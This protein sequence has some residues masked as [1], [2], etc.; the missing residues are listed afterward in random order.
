MSVYPFSF[1]T[2]HDDFFVLELLSDTGSSLP[3][4]QVEDDMGR[5]AE[6]CGLR[7]LR[8]VKSERKLTALSTPSTDDFCPVHLR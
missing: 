8:W 1:C 3:M 7:C 5:T 4:T 2:R 6:N